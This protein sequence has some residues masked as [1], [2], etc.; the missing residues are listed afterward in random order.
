M[1]SDRIPLALQPKHLDYIANV[2]ASR[3]WAEVNELLNDLQQ[4]VAAHNRVMT[5][6]VTKG[7]GHDVQQAADSH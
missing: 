7:N 2:L 1:P 6:P 4:Q 3:P 5:E